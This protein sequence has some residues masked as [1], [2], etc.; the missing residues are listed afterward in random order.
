M[1]GIPIN[2]EVFYPLDFLVEVTQHI[3]N[4][5]EHHVRYYG[6]YSN[7]KR[8]MQEKKK[9]KAE[10]PSSCDDPDTPYKK[11]CRMTWAM[12]IKAVFEVDPLKCPKCGGTMRLSPSL[13]KVRTFGKS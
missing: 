13:E 4:K 5:G 8:G 7:K 1:A 9:P 12:L 3:P 10:S 6:W 2:F 11:R